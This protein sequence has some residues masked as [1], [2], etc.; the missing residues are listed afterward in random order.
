MFVVRSR[1]QFA[2]LRTAS[3]RVEIEGSEGSRGRGE[4]DAGGMRGKWSA[5]CVYAA[6]SEM[7]PIV[8]FSDIFHR[9]VLVPD[10]ARDPLVIFGLELMTD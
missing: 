1:C 3:W 2:F 8:D 9:K 5:E 4:S 7:G 6:A 10:V